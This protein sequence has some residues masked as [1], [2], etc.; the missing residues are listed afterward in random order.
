LRAGL[1]TDTWKLSVDDYV[2]S[3]LELLESMQAGYNFE[4]PIPV[5]LNGELLNGSHRVACAIALG[6]DDIPVVTESRHVWA[7][8]WDDAWFSTN[9]ASHSMLEN[10]RGF[11][12]DMLAQC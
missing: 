11:N 4:F 3:A 12:K 2:S 7:P 8:A 6:I 9:C 1:A 10:I 5:D